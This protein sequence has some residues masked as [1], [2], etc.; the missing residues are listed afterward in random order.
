MIQNT[1]ICT[2]VD[3]CAPLAKKNERWI[4][5]VK[6]VR[7]FLGCTDNY[8]FLYTCQRSFVV[9]F[10]FVYFSAVCQRK[11]KQQAHV[12]GYK[13]YAIHDLVDV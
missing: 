11:K 8:I 2:L 6:C 4:D 9:L 5:R 12:L 1:T 13:T 10:A 7:L 3:A